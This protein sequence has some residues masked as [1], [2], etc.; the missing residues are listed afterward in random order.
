MSFPNVIITKDAQLLCTVIG[1]FTFSILLFTSTWSVAMCCVYVALQKL[2]AVA[3]MMSNLAFQL[4]SKF[5]GQHLGNS[6]FKALCNQTGTVLFLTD[7]AKWPTQYMLSGHDVIIASCSS[8][9][10]CEQCFGYIINGQ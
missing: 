4:S 5:I 7:L 10:I 2:Q 9:A 6:V 3:W 1:P 8:I